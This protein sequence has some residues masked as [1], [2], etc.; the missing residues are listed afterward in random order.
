VG[1]DPKL[2][3]LFKMALTTAKRQYLRVQG[4]DRPKFVPTNI[5]PLINTAWERSFACSELAAKRGGYPLNY[6]LLDDPKVIKQAEASIN[7]SNT[8]TKISNNDTCYSNNHSDKCTAVFRLNTDGP[9]ESDYVDRLLEE[10]SKAA[11]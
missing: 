8:V 2:N 10:K 1:D 11:G 7:T 4:L 5:I 9:L 6:M 3:G